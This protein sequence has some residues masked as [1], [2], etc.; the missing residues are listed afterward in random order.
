MLYTSLCRQ[1]WHSD[2][3]R[4]KVTSRQTNRPSAVR[5]RYADKE[6][7]FHFVHATHCAG[8]FCPKSNAPCADLAH[9]PHVHSSCW[10]FSVKSCPFRIHFRTASHHW[11]DVSD[12]GRRPSCVPMPGYE[13]AGEWRIALPTTESHREKC[14]IETLLT[15]F[16]V[17]SSDRSG[18]QDE[19]RRVLILGEACS[20][21]LLQVAECFALAFFI[22]LQF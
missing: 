12:L 3:V 21:K 5:R 7:S 22:L 13:S 6:R 4:S 18:N 16:C 2:S 19:F 17:T 11:P 9:G 15:E 14:G 1:R 20:F 8:L 10:P